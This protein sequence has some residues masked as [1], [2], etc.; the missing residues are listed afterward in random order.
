[1]EILDY[2]NFDLGMQSNV[3][4][5][6][7]YTHSSSLLTTPKVIQAL[8]KV[9][10]DHPAL[11]SIFVSRPFQKKEG[12]HELWEARL[13]GLRAKDCIEFVN[14]E[15]EV[16][17]AKV[18]ES[19]HN[20]WLDTKNTT[21]PLWKLCVI[22][23]RYAVFIFHHAI[24]D[25]L[26]GYAFH[27]SF[28]AA[29]NANEVSPCSPEPITQ[30]DVLTLKEPVKKLAPSPFDHIDEKFSWPYII[31]GF[32]CWTLLRF[33][34]NKKYFLFSDAIFPK[35]YPTLSN[36]FAI[37]KRT[38]T[39]AEILRIDSGAME[40]CL[41]EC[42]KHNT[43]FTALLHTL[44][45]VTLATDIYPKAKFG[46]PRLAVNARPL[47]NI[48]LRRDVFTNA[49]STYY[50]VQPLGPYRS[51]A[52]IAPA[53]SPPT[54]TLDRS[55]IWSLAQ[56]YKAALHHSTYTSCTVTQDFLVCKTIAG[57]LEDVSFAHHSLY[58]NNSFLV[59][60]L[61]VFEPRDEM[62]D[63]GWS[64]DGV[65][66]SAAA[67]RACVSDAGVVFDVASVRGGEC[68]VVGVWEEGVLEEVV[69]ELLRAV[70]GR[71]DLLLI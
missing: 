13:P 30:D 60:N 38:R 64:V 46:F 8:S 26:S 19:A 37:E 70:R 22:N 11:A 21:K 14:D 40:K 63:G 6:T 24:A 55:K 67:V 15:G 28:L 66:F 25:G 35:T 34:V 1:M 65:G 50:R 71:L 42:R 45:Q 62:E 29:L 27:R 16:D 58:M 51:A 17:L 61:G 57:D 36:H 3:L 49:A 54:L 23:G 12:N 69:R 68:V 32:L 44:I 48:D 59:S 18:F 7:S 4:V 5:S 41:S 9:I 20:E 56:T 47:L 39:K 33:F 43:S 31:Y 52:N 53:N 10:N 2:L